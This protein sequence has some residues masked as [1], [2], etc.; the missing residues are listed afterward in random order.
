M[1]QVCQNFKWLNVSSCQSVLSCFK[2]QLLLHCVALDCA[3]AWWLFFL[4]YP[5][6][7]QGTPLG[8]CGAQD[9]RLGANAASDCMTA[10]RWASVLAWA[11]AHPCGTPLRL[12]RSLH[13]AER[14]YFAT[15][16]CACAACVSAAL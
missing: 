4:P 6:F 13:G 15:C 11:A 5:P 14:T 8:R 7:C 1:C 3:C 10:K 2:M 12:R 9:S 16:L